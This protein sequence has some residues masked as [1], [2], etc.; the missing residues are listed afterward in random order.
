[1]GVVYRAWDE[2]LQRH[3]AV[4][5][6]RPEVAARPEARERF[7]REARSAAR[8][9]HPHVIAIHHVGEEGGVPFL[10]MPLLEGESLAAR[11]EREEVLPPAEVVRI[12]REAAEG[13]AAAHEKGVVHRDVK[14]ANLWLEAPSGA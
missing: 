3:V 2:V 11:L 13:L 9:N 14:P 12:G 7:L 1:M 4:K 5:V 10:V 8:L 6:M